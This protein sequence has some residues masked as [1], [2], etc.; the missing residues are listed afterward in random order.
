MTAPFSPELL[1][2]KAGGASTTSVT[3]TWKFRSV[4][5]GDHMATFAIRRR[6]MTPSVGS[7]EYWNGS[8][9]VGSETFLSGPSGGG[10]EV[11]DGMTHTVTVATGW[12]TDRVYQWSVK[13]R[14]AAAE[15]SAYADD[16]L[17]QVHA[18]PTM[19]LTVSSTTISRPR[20]SWV[21]AG[22]AGYYQKSYRLVLYPASVIGIAGFDAAS[23]VY[24][25]M[26]VWDSGKIFSAT[27][28]NRYVTADLQSGVQYY[29]YY[30]TEDNSDLSSG[31]VSATNFTPSYTAVPPPT[32][33]IAPNEDL[34]IVTLTARSSFNLLDDDHSIFTAGIGNWIG[35]HNCESSWDSSLGKLKLTAGGMSYAALDTAYTTFAAQ[36]TALTTFEAQ[37]TTQASP[38]GT[39]RALSGDQTGERI[40]VTP[41]VAYSAIATARNLAGTARTGKLGIRWYTAA[42]AASTTPV[43]QGSATTLNPGVDTT[44]KVENI[45]APADA[46]WAVIEFEWTTAA[47][48]D[49]ILID[50]VALATTSTIVWSPSGNNFDIS[51]VI[52]RSIDNAKW[53]PVWGCSSSAPKASDSGAV[54]QVIVE[55]RSAP[56]GTQNVYYRAYAISKYSTA[57]VWSAV[58]TASISGMKPAKWFLRRC[59]NAAK[60]VR[61]RAAD[62]STSYSMDQDLYTPEGATRAVVSAGAGPSVEVVDVTLRTETKQEHDL[63]MENL[64]SKETL[65][66]QTNADGDGYYI[67]PIDRIRR[68]QRR[69]VPDEAYQAVRYLFS[70]SF[71]AAVVEDYV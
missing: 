7:Y 40:A 70:V 15:A 26:A 50:D 60:D 33:N 9:W 49:V 5:A 27:D 46:A 18:A 16:S 2:P 13:C 19:T 47:V 51:F 61:I 11:K 32:L 65:Y 53:V 44:V 10:T 62:F 54:S 56:L 45:T 57:P 67:R 12:T 34:G 43:S 36:D 52:E 1:S 23:A 22:A 66:I 63:V 64:L 30:Q 59:K 38:T 28:W 8:A 21:W 39:A 55:D 58:A 25:A 71:T 6:Q 37:R 35:S 3:M 31:W 48:G 42:H 14:N 17:V 20:L 4:A 41:A 24:Q 68:E 29:L 69:S